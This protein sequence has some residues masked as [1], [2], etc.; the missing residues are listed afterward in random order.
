MTSRSDFTPQQLDAI[1]GRGNLLVVA[2]AG[3][4][5]TRT[6]VARCLRLVAE[7]R[8]SLEN[9]L[10]VTFTEAAAGEM[11]ARIGRGLRELQAARPDDEH[12]AQQLALLDTARICTLHSFCLQL[13]REHF[14]EL[15]LDPQFSVLDEQ[16]T[17]PLIRAT[18]DEVLERHYSGNDAQARAAQAL[19]RAVG[20]GTDTRI[21]KLTRK[22]HAYSQSLPDP[23]RWLDE[24]QRRFEQAEPIEWREWFLAAVV[25]WRDEWKET[26]SA[27]VGEA[28]AVQLCCDALE[29]LPANPSPADA[30]TVL[31]AVQEA[32][33]DD[34]NWPRGTKGKARD[35]IRNF[36]GD[37]EFLGSLLPDAMGNDPL[38]QDWEWARHHM[39]ALVSLTREFTAAFSRGKRELGGVDFADLEQCALRLL[40]DPATAREWRARLA[41]VFVDEYQDINEAQDTIITALSRDG[42]T[43]GGAEPAEGG[44]PN[45]GNR[46]LVGDVK[47]SIYRFR[48]ANPKIFSGYDARWFAP[49]SEGRRI[50][51]T[52][53]FRS[54]AALLDFINP[55][56]AALMREAVGG[57]EYEA[58]EFGAPD[59]RVALA[60]KPGDG[61]RAEFHLI[62][63]A[64][65]PAAGDE[66]E[67]ENDTPEP[68]PDLLA[69]EREA[70]LLARRLRELKESRHEI[71]DGEEDIFRPV[72][73]SDMAVLLR[74]PSGR[75]EAFAK[76]FSK[77]GVPLVAARD[78]FFE[79]LEVTDLVN[80]LKLLDNP[81]QDVPL[82]AV[83]RS[84]LAGLSLD[85][86]AEVRAHNPE[87][88]F[89]T[90]LVVF[91]RE[92]MQPN[93][94]GGGG[95]GAPRL[96][97]WT[98]T[99][100]FLRQFARWR[101]VVRQT[102][103]SHCLDTVLAETQY[104]ALLLAERRGN[105]RAANV[106]RLLDLA[107]QFDPYQRQ[108]LYRFLRFIKAQEDEDLD[109]QPASPPAE[110]AVRL[111]SV[112]KSKGLEFPVVALA[113]MGTCFNEQDLNEP[114]LL[115][116]LYGLCPKITPPDAEQSYPG[117]P[118]WLARRGERRELRG[119]ELRLFYVALT[120]ARDTLILAG[121]ANRKA[122]DVKWQAENS[123]GISTAAVAEARSHLDW[124]LTW[125]PRATTKEDWRDEHGGRNRILRWHIYDEN[126]PLFADW[127][128]PLPETCIPTAMS[129]PDEAES[130]EELKATLAWQYPFVTATTETAK[131]SVSMLRRRMRDETD[132]EAKPLFRFKTSQR[133]TKG[134]GRLSA[135]QIGS[136]HHLFLQFAALEKLDN[137]GAL[138]AETE[139]LRDEGVMTAEE[140]AVLDVEAI[141]AFWQSEIGKRILARRE[142]VHR[143][144]PFTARFSPADLAAC[145]LSL[146]IAPDEFVVVQGIADLAVIL[147]NE[148]WLVDFKT[149]ESR[150]TELAEKVNIYEPQLK[151]YARALARIYQR[152]VTECRLCFLSQ[153]SNVRINM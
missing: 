119:E 21:R 126:D 60:A 148:I 111:M 16:Q 147:P 118:H 78:G 108:G 23:A 74:S 84:P 106:R 32:D 145:G 71:R 70:R 58:L 3:T 10:M 110:D 129:G 38:A 26:V 83:L 136:A 121:T 65:D 53:N 115:S 4:G 112:H 101:E 122:G 66:P 64:R 73:W 50:S 82:L 25:A 28:R 55:L 57:V 35:P 95:D 36:F 152:P 125:L 90:A 59:R 134:D 127:I 131:T 114:V 109:L 124:L 9:I 137:A 63:R 42:G 8:A 51:L 24:Q 99:D 14:H 18:L 20:H 88:Y 27:F 81:L 92:G 54:P 15:G 1:T 39:A 130:I 2:G 68:V 45:R 140:T 104:E 56:F 40:R 102:S 47:Q 77:A 149:D 17:R 22:L 120:R 13:A 69:V 67:E 139:R 93:S 49:G 89:W 96:S 61:P 151:M 33:S 116:E 153:R 103:L 132:D 94:P 91:H 62:A 133:T 29:N 6:L 146:N 37:A 113:C 85:E 97:A 41:H 142:H 5:K 107:R 44:T 117:L 19:I 31:R 150:K 100:L 143:E 123:G 80:L 52:E 138:K 11:R 72:R 7:E 75:A 48:L 98:K 30:A 105:E 79:S 135:A 34:D 86:L 87:K 76:E 12:L 141:A 43:A 128:A 144:I 46:F